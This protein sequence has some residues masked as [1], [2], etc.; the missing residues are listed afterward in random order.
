M[1]PLRNHV[2]VGGVCMGLAWLHGDACPLWDDKKK[3]EVGFDPLVPL[4]MGWP[5]T[6]FNF[7]HPYHFDQE[8]R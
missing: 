1:D 3:F 6:S 4:P 7:L 2:Y 5:F 8:R